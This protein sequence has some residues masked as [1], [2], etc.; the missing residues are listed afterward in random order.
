MMLNKQKEY[1]K[2]DLTPA[3]RAVYSGHKN[4]IKKNQA[5]KEALKS[6]ENLDIAALY[7]LETP[8]EY[9]KYIT[10]NEAIIFEEFLRKII[11]I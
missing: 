5:I 1:V 7:R 4:A 3:P 2:R 10:I 6:N 9:V 11:T 8:E